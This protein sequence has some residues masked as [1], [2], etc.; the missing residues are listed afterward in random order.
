MSQE[1]DR[2]RRR[3][4]VLK[5][6]APVNPCYPDGRRTKRRGFGWRCPDVP[7][8]WQE[9]PCPWNGEGSSVYSL[10]SR[11]YPLVQQDMGEES[12]VATYRPADRSKARFREDVLLL[13]L[14]ILPTIGWE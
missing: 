10:N 2:L 13:L 14:A 1:E 11:H 8:D 5:F 6:S 4:K 9:L 3:G 7:E 12:V